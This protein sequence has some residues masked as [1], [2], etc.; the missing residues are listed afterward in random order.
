VATTED[1]VLEGGTGS[2]PAPEGAVGSDLALA[3][4]AGCNPA[5]EGV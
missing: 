2:Y 3:G 5:L 1:L 4:S